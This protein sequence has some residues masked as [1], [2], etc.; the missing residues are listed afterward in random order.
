MLTQA[1]RVTRTGLDETRRALQALRATPLQDLG[2]RLGIQELAEAVA[3]R[4]GLQ[5]ELDLQP[6][7]GRMIPELEQCAYRVAQEALENV[8]RHANAR[9]VSVLL[10]VA[11]GRLTLEVTDDAFVDLG[12][13]RRKIGSGHIGLPTC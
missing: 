1:L 6:M 12:E 7:Q 8:L 5:L 3:A 4:G 9:R 2:L 13:R 10:R 11:A